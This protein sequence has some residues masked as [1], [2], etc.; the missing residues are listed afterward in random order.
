MIS[1]GKINTAV[2]GADAEDGILGNAN[3]IVIT[4]IPGN[5]T[6]Y[7]N[8]V[9]VTLNQQI[10]NFNP[11]LVSFG[12]ITNGST[13]VVFKYAFVDAAGKQDPTPANYT[14]SWTG[15]L[16]VTLERFSAT[17]ENDQVQLTWRTLT[18]QNV[19]RFI[20]EYSTDGINFNAIATVAAT[21]NSSIPVNY[22]WIHSSPVAGNNYYRLKMVDI[23]DRFVYSTVAV[24]KMSGSTDLV[25]SA[26]PNPVHY[27][28]NIWLP[29]PGTTH[30]ILNVYS[31][32]GELVY[33]KATGNVQTILL[34]VSTFSKGI[35]YIRIM[36]NGTALYNAKFVKQ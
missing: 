26:Y 32:D 19:S 3:K 10:T 16:P 30:T 11:A 36:E 5:A 18:E 24:I 21:G 29:K 28:L 35:Y 8:G 7:Y 12:G 15:A 17:K 4:N 34:P 2:S 22:T 33:S 25:I 9:S 14:I 23:D 31:N 1:A 13:S 27:L 20:I 6:M